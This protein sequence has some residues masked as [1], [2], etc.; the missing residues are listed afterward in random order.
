MAHCKTM[1]NLAEVGDRRVA[2]SRTPQFRS[3][4]RPRNLA[5]TFDVFLAATSGSPAS[6]LRAPSCR[7]RARSSSSPRQCSPSQL[8]PLPSALLPPA[9]P[10]VLRTGPS[11]MRCGMVIPWGSAPERDEPPPVEP[12]RPCGRPSRPLLGGT[13]NTVCEIVRDRLIHNLQTLTSKTR[14]ASRYTTQ[15]RQAVS[16][17]KSGNPVSSQLH[18]NHSDT[19]LHNTRAAS[20]YTTSEQQ[21]AMVTSAQSGNPL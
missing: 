10:G 21:A 2:G 12:S 18:M 1:P 19:P 9:S 8:V 3:C 14:A 4:R 16:R 20:R 7:R 5:G 6:R 13:R 11:T 15:E 17:H